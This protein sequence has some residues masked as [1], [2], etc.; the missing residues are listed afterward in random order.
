MNFI[1]NFFG[2]SPDGGS[3]ILESILILLPLASVLLYWSYE[4]IGPW[5]GKVNNESS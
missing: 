5:V 4:K 3:G 2:I 1:E